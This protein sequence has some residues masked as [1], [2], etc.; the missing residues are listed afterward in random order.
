[1]L[2]VH[3][4]T[5]TG[6]VAGSESEYDEGDSSIFR[7]S[8]QPVCGFSML[9]Q[10]R[11]CAIWLVWLFLEPDT[12]LYHCP[13]ILLSRFRAR[14]SA[15]EFCEFCCCSS[16]TD[17]KLTLLW[18]WRLMALNSEEV[19]L[20]GRVLGGGL[21]TVPV[22]PLPPVPLPAPPGPSVGGSGGLPSR[23]KLPPSSGGNCIRIGLPGK[24]ILS[25]RKCFW[26]SHIL[27]KIVFKNRFSGKTYF[28][29]LVPGTF[30]TA[31]EAR[32]D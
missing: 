8:C 25:K 17:W 23:A 19:Q 14:I 26:G 12:G 21:G 24:L 20:L 4:S 2:S 27:S 1:M 30:M 10:V 3:N 5:E 28:T 6:F 13:R 7:Q 32:T 15:C 11:L 22:P 9:K 18:F 16:R 31:M 29:Q